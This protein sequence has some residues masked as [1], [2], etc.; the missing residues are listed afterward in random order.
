[1][2]AREI[3]EHSAHLGD[4]VPRPASGPKPVGAGLEVNLKDRLE[5]QLEG[6]LNDTV[7]HRR[8]P[9]IAQLAATLRDRPLLDRIRPK[10]PGPQLLTEPSQELLDASAA[11]V[12]T[13]LLLTQAMQ[14]SRE[15]RRTLV[16]RN[17]SERVDRRLARCPFRD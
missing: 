6:G 7:A 11:R 4:R 16:L 1:V 15:R 3:G 13:A 14:Q 9:Q 12:G 17:E 2:S 8:D 10:A 5:H